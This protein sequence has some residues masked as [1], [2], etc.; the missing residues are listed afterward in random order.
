[1]NHTSRNQGRQM[2]AARQYRQYTQKEVCDAVKGLSQSNL[3][4]FEKGFKNALSQDKI[5]KIMYFLNW[6]LSWLDEKI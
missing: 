3:S 1:M 2:K 4:R 5:N 6:P